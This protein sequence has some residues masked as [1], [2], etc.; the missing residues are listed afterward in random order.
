M[1]E[2]LMV[3]FVG[4]HQPHVIKKLQEKFYCERDGFSSNETNSINYCDFDFL[5]VHTVIQQ[6]DVAFL[7]FFLNIC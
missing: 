7:D 4:A 6:P 3:F 1:N 5:M 2:F